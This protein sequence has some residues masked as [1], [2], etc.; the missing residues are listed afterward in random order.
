MDASISLQV[1]DHRRVRERDLHDSFDDMAIAEG[2]EEE[3]DN[4]NQDITASA[5][6]AMSNS[7]NATWVTRPKTATDIASTVYKRYNSLALSLSGSSSR[8][9]SSRRRHSL[10][11]KRDTNNAFRSTQLQY[12]ATNSQSL[13]ASLHGFDL[14]NALGSGSEPLQAS[15]SR[16]L[17]LKTLLKDKQKNRSSLSPKPPKNRTSSSAK[18]HRLN[19]SMSNLLNQSNNDLLSMSLNRKPSLSMLRQTSLSRQTSAGERCLS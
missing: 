16:D 9:T 12:H 11:P 7:S 5:K 18:L 15:V 17:D 4:S 1:P 14:S 8:G 13:H 6:A 10:S 19:E 3:E 2:D